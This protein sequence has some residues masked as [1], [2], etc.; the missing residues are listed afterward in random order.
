VRIFVR[1]L[2]RVTIGTELC[3]KLTNPVKSIAIKHTV[4]GNQD[5]KLETLIFTG[6]QKPVALAIK[7][8]TEATYD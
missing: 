2:N 1:F 3:P 8:T 7:R 5:V 4:T 6:V